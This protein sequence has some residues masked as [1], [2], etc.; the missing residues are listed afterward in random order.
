MS[1]YLSKEAAIDARIRRENQLN[2]NEIDIPSEANP[3]KFAESPV[4]WA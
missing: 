1:S 4:L 2:E 3:G